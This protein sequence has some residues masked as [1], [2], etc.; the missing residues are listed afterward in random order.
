MSMRNGPP[1]KTC[2]FKECVMQKISYLFVF[3]LLLCLVPQSVCAWAKNEWLGIVEVSCG[4]A[5]I[6]TDAPAEPDSSECDDCGGSGWLGDG[7]V[8]VRCQACNP[9]KEG[10]VDSKEAIKSA[11]PT[12]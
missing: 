2:H 6:D 4:L 11:G 9:R 5:V 1:L 3:L 10:P 12:F 8:K 7:T